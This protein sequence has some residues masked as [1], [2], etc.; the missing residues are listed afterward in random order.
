MTNDT[1]AASTGHC[2]NDVASPSDTPAPS[3]TVIQMW[4]LIAR[5]VLLPGTMIICLTRRNG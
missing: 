2:V 4:L 1:N 3:P 5:A